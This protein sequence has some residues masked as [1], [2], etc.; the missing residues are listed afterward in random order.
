[1]PAEIDG[2]P[3]F[4]T[5]RQSLADLDEIRAALGYDRINLWGGSWGTRA[6]LLFALRYPAVTRTVILDGAVALTM[7]FPRTASADAQAALDRLIDRCREDAAAARRFPIRT[8]RSI[9]SLALQ[10]RRGH[11]HDPS[12]ANA[13]AGRR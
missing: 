6:A 12:P 10:R 4:Y 2:D 7:G 8:R 1:M 5:H 9:G 11:G 13:P 3:R